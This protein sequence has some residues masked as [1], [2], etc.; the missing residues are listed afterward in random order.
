MRRR[1]TFS[2]RALR[3]FE[4]IHD[5]IAKDSA[6]AALDFVGCLQKQ[7]EELVHFPHIGRKRDE[8]TPGC[9]SVTQGEYVIF[10]QTGSDDSLEVM[11]IVHGKRDLSRIAFTD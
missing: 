5:Y 1:L 9:K 7:C 10:Y 2:V 3:D 6:D 11:R 4:E 8:I